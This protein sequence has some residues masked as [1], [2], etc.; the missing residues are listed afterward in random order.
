VGYQ[1]GSLQAQARRSFR[2]ADA[3]ARLFEDLPG[4]F[5]IREWNIIFFAP[6]LR[7]CSPKRV[8]PRQLFG[9]PPGL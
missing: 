5:T 6:E 1:R 8:L 9:L 7:I 3:S 2:A 4:A